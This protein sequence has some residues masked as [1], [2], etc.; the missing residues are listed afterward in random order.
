MVEKIIVEEP[1]K[2]NKSSDSTVELTEVVTGTAPAY[3]L[4]DGEVVGTEQ[5]LAWLGQQIWQ[6][7]KNTG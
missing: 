7:K 1:K 3:K 2:N 5:Y 4:P 6:I